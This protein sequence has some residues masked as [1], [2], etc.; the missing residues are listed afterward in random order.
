[1]LKKIMASLA[2]ATLCLT[3]TAC[4]MPWEDAKTPSKPATNT[5]G[6]TTENTANASKGLADYSYLNNVA[7]TEGMAVKVYVDGTA[8]MAGYT[9]NN[10]PSVYKDIVKSLE[11]LFNARWK[12]NKINRCNKSD[13]KNDEYCNCIYRHR[14]IFITKNSRKQ[15]K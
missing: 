2:V 12:S 11:P 5:S 9:N 15:N 8:S 1:M 3:L 10:A 6:A 4:K 14:N 7:V 13:R